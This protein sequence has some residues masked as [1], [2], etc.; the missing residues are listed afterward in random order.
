M[1]M[2]REIQSLVLAAL[3]CGTAA[4]TED[5]DAALEALKKKAHR[6][7]Y[8][9]RAVLADRELTVP[10]PQ[11]DE[12]AALDA[13]LLEMEQSLSS[14][15][16]VQAR[17]MPR[18]SPMRPLPRQE[19]NNTW[20]TP[21]LLDNSADLDGPQKEQTPWINQELERQKNRQLE[22]AALAKEQDLITRQVNDRLENQA[23]SPFNPAEGY[24]RSLQEVIGGLS[25]NESRQKESELKNLS[26]QQRPFAINSSSSRSLIPST[27]GLTQA[28]G[29]SLSSGT[30]MFQ[31][32]R[33]TLK[34]PTDFN[35]KWDQEPET[36]TPLKKLRK[37]SL[38][39]HDPFSTDF[40]PRINKGI[41]D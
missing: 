12:D 23:A 16:P 38:I 24:S 4:A 9:S 30:E 35:A 26:G 11:S 2:R 10:S 13:K 14:E 33:S 19:E 41:W 22:Q 39:D 27:P 34:P 7:D 15:N 36:L 21:A 31:I 20:L 3:L 37:S 32:K 6:R 29:N 40:A 8:S 18:L 5:L 17:P 25:A 1:L 28:S